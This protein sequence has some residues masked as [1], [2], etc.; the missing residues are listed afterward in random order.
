MAKLSDEVREVMNELFRDNG[1]TVCGKDV[2]LKDE[3]YYHVAKVSK[4]KGQ[5][6]LGFC[7]IQCVNPA[8]V[9]EDVDVAIGELCDIYTSE[10]IY[11]AA[12]KSLVIEAQK[13]R[14]KKSKV[15]F[16]QIAVSHPDLIVQSNAEATKANVNK[17]L[18]EQDDADKEGLQIF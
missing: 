17:W 2:M 6:L 3:R 15:D 5:T 4:D 10:K 1:Y 11:K 14:D 13:C 18:S 9:V 8:D 16:I 7:K 12:M